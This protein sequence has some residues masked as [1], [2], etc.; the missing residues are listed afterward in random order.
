[1]AVVGGALVL[2]AAAIVVVGNWDAIGRGAR[3]AGLAL[4]TG[5]LLLVSERCRTA[6]PLTASIIAH[7][8]TFLTST[9]GIAA[10][11]LFGFTWPACLAVGGTLAAAATQVQRSRW[12]GDAFATGQV[13]ALAIAATGVAALIGAAGGLVAA[14]SAAMLLA[15]GAERRA[16]GLA[17]LAVCSPAL[18]ALADAG[19]GA[20]TFERAGLVGDRLGWS[21][22]VVGVVA[23]LVI[24]VVATRRHNNGLMAAA[25]LAPVV[26]AV[27]GL[28]AI[29]GSAVAWWCLPGLIVLASELTWWILPNERCRRRFDAVIDGLAVILAAGTAVLAVPLADELN[30]DIASSSFAVPL[31][32]TLPALV[33]ATARWRTRHRR[34]ADAGLAAIG[35][36]T[37]GLGWSL[38]IGALGLATGA[39]AATIAVGVLSHRLHPLACYVPAFWTLLA[40]DNVNADGASEV[41]VWAI[42]LLAVQTGFLVW[43][44]ARRAGDRLWLG[45]VE[46][47]SIA[48]A[49]LVTTGSLFD[50]ASFPAAPASMT[51]VALVCGAFVLAERRIES[52]ATTVAA[53]L[54]VIITIGAAF[55]QGLDRLWVGTSVF[56]A[57]AAAAWFAHRTAMS[58][59]ACAAAAAFS[60]AFAAADMSITAERFV[61]IAAVAVVTLTG[62]GLLLR[63]PS[64]IDAAGG[65]AATALI[66]VAT[67]G[68][69]ATWASF[70]WTLVGLQIAVLGWS[71]HAI[72]VASVGAFVAV[73]GLVS[74]WYT[75]GWHDLVAAWLEPA[76]VRVGDLWLAAAA[77]VAA[78]VGRQARRAHDIASWLADGPALAIV[79]VWLIPAQVDRS[80]VWAMPL[81]LLVGVVSVA[82]GGRY[83]LVAPLLGGAA[84]TTATVF[85]ATGSDVRALPAW[86]W[87]AVGGL[88]LLGTAIAI[89]R[90]NAADASLKT[91]IDRWR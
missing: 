14:V 16:A 81:S 90:A 12:A 59:S 32:V 78:I 52:V 54:G 77:G 79:A 43:V 33:V 20:G 48:I 91:L 23:A 29:D 30:A 18:A 4:G 80:T 24:A 15:V 89:E 73:C 37:I 28:A 68:T 36:A 22:P 70:A 87:F 76:D 5:A 84:I 17:L 86:V 63:R 39:V 56:A 46:V 2:V 64:P 66:V 8:G 75:S 21:G 41:L 69:D 53:A 35:A 25:A 47:A 42:G 27:T 49:A 51:A 11:S 72:A 55:D 40:I 74:W 82:L 7:V 44:R 58:S 9:V 50:E 60:A 45:A 57:I 85:V 71:R 26:G 65:A 83:R 62:L 19:V 10:M 13:V 34:L 61:A 67:I 38:Q 31:A 3:V 88:A 6:T 1:M